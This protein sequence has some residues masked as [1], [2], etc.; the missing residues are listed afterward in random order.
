MR[1]AYVS[2]ILHAVKIEISSGRTRGA[3]WWRLEV[4]TPIPMSYHVKL[5]AYKRER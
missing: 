3:S 1:C 4:N 5:C 2:G